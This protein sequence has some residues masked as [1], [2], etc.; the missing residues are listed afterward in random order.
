MKREK[1]TITKDNYMKIM[2]K[3]MIILC[4]VVLAICFI[5]KLCGGNFFNV[6]C[7]NE[8]FNAMCNFIEHNFAL[9]FIMAFAFN[10]ALSLLFILTID[11]RIKPSKFQ[12]I[13]VLCLA[14]I[15]SL[16][17]VLLVHFNLSKF[18]TIIDVAHM[19]LF[20]FAVKR[21]LNLI[22]EIIQYVAFMLVSSL[23]KGV[24]L[25]LTNE[26]FVVSIIMS[27]DVLIMLTLNYL[28]SNKRGDIFMGVLFIFLSKD[29]AQLEAYKATLKDPKKIAKVDARIAELKA[30]EEKK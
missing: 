18:T 16:S 23:I 4:W 15:I 27:I 22:C 9:Y 2:L 17:K 6:V 24:S 5:I 29:I 13:Y 19:I 10:L 30:K 8:K 14:T 3:R 25:N 28:Y 12:L 1:V 11:S 26:P 21:K 7:K 20:I